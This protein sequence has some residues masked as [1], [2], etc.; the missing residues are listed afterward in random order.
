M[1]ERKSQ[2]NPMSGEHV[3]VDGVY[4]NEWG[5]QV[6]MARGDVFPA[7]PVLGNTEW[8]LS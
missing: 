5:R 7:D 4:K 6:Q 8:Q 2:M 1:S 3:E